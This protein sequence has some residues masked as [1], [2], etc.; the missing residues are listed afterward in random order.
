[1]LRDGQASNQAEAARK[2]GV[3]RSR[4]TQLLNLTHL[5]KPIKNYLLKTKDG[6]GKIRER[7]LRPLTQLHKREQIQAFRRLVGTLQS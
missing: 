1:M 6:N 5:A 3:S 4:I 2:I 7:N